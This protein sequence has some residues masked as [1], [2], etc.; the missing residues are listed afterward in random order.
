MA[1][2]ASVTK[3]CVTTF[4]LPPADPLASEICLYCVPAGPAALWPAER[5]ERGE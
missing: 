5:D 1:G 2:P 3:L 4:N